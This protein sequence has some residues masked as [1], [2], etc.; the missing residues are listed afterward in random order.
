M[1]VVALVVEKDWY[2]AWERLLEAGKDK[3]GSLAEL[4]RQAGLHYNQVAGVRTKGAKN[5]GGTSLLRL[6]EAAGIPKEEKDDL[7]WMWICLKAQRKGEGRA[8]VALV[9]DL[10]RAMSGR[11]EQDTLL[12]AKVKS[13]LVE[14]YI[15]ELAKGD[16]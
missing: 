13:M 1:V 15:L 10:T 16:D 7:L 5:I 12:A 14:N 3:L 4:C 2:S 8:L 9:N 6:A 11:S